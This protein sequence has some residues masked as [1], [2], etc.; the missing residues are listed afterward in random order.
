MFGCIFQK[1]R[2]ILA[3]ISDIQISLGI[4][5]RLSLANPE[6]KLYEEYNHIIELEEIFW[7]RKS[8]N[9]WL[10]E[11]DRNMKF[12]HMSMMV[13]R[14][15]NMLEG[16]KGEDGVWRCDKESMRD[17]A[18][19][20]FKNLFLG[21]P[22]AINYD[23]ISQLFPYLEDNVIADL[24][25]VVSEEEVRYGLFGIR[26]LKKPGLDGYHA[27]FFQN[28]WD[29]FKE[30]LVKFMVVS[31]RLRMFP[32]ELNQ[33]IITLV[34]KVL[35]PLDM[36]KLR[37]I[38]LRNIIYKIPDNIIVAQEVLHKFRIMKGKQRCIAWKIDIAKAYD[39]LQWN[40]IRSVL[41]K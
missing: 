19:S 2:R 9:T 28:Q 33:T 12:F 10:I 13:T 16:L 3:R 7:L 4:R 36:T 24:S 39:K 25:K 1:K 38:S 11:G 14:R 27:I 32:A 29:V 6:V 18:T 26:G 40:F 34:P 15:R 31:F 20:Y 21:M 23:C 37:P 22:C 8:R 5:F 17:V 30:G 35:S 41:L